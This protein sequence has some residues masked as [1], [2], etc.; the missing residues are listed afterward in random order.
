MINAPT[1]VQEPFAWFAMGY[2]CLLTIVFFL[3]LWFK[4]GFLYAPQEYK[5]E[6]NFMSLIGGGRPAPSKVS[7]K[8]DELVLE[9]DSLRK[10]IETILKK[11]E[12]DA[13]DAI[14]NQEAQRHEQQ[15]RIAE[16]QRIPLISFMIGELQLSMVDVFASIKQA[17]NASI[18]PDVVFNVT[19]DPKKRLR[20]ERLLQSFA[21]A[22]ADFSHAKT[23]INKYNL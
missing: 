6:E 12:P 19:S 7:A 10:Y 21:K 16:I 14:I 23:L 5:Q 18:L 1:A 11:V 20:L 4:P 15:S 22:A 2:P 3:F 9:V 17:D 8:V 13:S